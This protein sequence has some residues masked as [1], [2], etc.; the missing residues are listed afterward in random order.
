MHSLI[1]TPTD[2]Q[3]KENTSN[4]HAKDDYNNQPD[5][6]T[7]Q[8]SRGHRYGHQLWLKLPERNSLFIWQRAD[9]MWAMWAEICAYHILSLRPTQA[10][11]HWLIRQ[12]FCQKAKVFPHI[13]GENKHSQVRKQSCSTRAQTMKLIYAPRSA[14]PCLYEMFLSLSHTNTHTLTLVVR[15]HL[16]PPCS[17][18]GLITQT[19]PLLRGLSLTVT[20][21]LLMVIGDTWMYEL[22]HTH[23]HIQT[24]HTKINNPA[25]RRMRDI[26]L[27]CR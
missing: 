21:P 14:L 19:A 27:G 24:K 22:T 26:S 9:W 7:P 10:D 17:L 13:R 23:T 18:W 11:K 12:D 15:R 25:V 8:Q 3:H 5:K 2:K 1:H 6:E 20:W 16:W 4:I